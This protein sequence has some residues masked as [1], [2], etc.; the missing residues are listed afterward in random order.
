[1]FTFDQRIIN[2]HCTFEKKVCNNQTKKK[3]ALVVSK[4]KIVRSQKKKKK[5]KNKKQ[6]FPMNKQNKSFYYDYCNH[7]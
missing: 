2:I 6:C 4:M 7:E 1:M 5:K 3:F